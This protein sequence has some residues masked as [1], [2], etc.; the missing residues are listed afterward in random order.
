MA[1]VGLLPEMMVT[2]VFDAI[3]ASSLEL[4]SLLYVLPETI[5]ASLPEAR[6]PQ[7]RLVQV[8]WCL[9]TYRTSDEHPPLR[10]FLEWATRMCGPRIEADVLR[11]A[12]SMLDDGTT[13]EQGPEAARQRRPWYLSMA[14]RLYRQQGF[15]DIESSEATFPVFVG[16]SDMRARVVGVTVGDL[17]RTIGAVQDHVR[18]VRLGAFSVEGHV[19]FPEMGPSFDE[20]RAVIDAGLLPMRLDDLRRRAERYVRLRVAPP[21]DGVIARQTA[22]AVERCKAMGQADALELLRDRTTSRLTELVND[23]RAARPCHWIILAP[24][25]G[26]RAIAGSSLLTAWN[27]IHRKL[28]GRWPL[29]L[30]LERPFPFD[31]DELLDSVLSAQ[32]VTSDRTVADSLLSD[33][34]SVP[35]FCCGADVALSHVQHLIQ[36][37]LARKQ[38]Y[39]I[40]TSESGWQSTPKFLGSSASSRKISSFPVDFE[41]DS[42]R[43]GNA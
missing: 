24:N 10:R 39:V 40:L 31:S 38:R 11:E 1:T 2:R 19:V 8:L 26:L 3:L 41:P 43:S 7:Q 30:P 37:I 33:D 16:W 4:D 15:A 13:A 22:W 6:A 32:R 5:R 29:Y 12:V 14:K 17:H 27:E 18:F 42:S 28:G 9:N 20:E 34:E 23:V 35:V 25:L 36:P 21:T